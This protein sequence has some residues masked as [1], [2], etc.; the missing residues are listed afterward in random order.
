M[1]LKVEMLLTARTAEL[2]VETAE[3]LAD[4]GDD[5]LLAATVLL[6]IAESYQRAREAEAAETIALE[7]LNAEND[8]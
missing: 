7:N 4:Q 5:G 6:R 2:F 1:K 8:E 3:R